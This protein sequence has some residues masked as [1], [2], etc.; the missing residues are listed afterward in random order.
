MKRAPKKAKAANTSR[1]IDSLT[2]SRAERLDVRSLLS[3]RERGLSK[4]DKRLICQEY[5]EWAQNPTNIEWLE[6]FHEVGI[7]ISTWQDWFRNDP[8]IRAVH[9]HVKTIMGA[10]HNKMARFPKQYDANPEAF[11]KTI[12]LFHPDYKEVY[13]EDMKHREKEAAGNVTVVLEGIEKTDVP[14]IDG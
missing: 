7:P 6:F 8:E 13:D 14:E 10:R 12:R 1:K 9:D 3:W 5:L 2:I 11:M 4:D